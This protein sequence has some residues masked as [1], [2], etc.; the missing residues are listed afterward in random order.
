M[1]VEAGSIGERSRLAAKYVS[2]SLRPCRLTVS[3]DIVNDSAAI[4]G[5]ATDS[6]VLRRREGDSELNETLSAPVGFGSS[7]SA[8][9]SALMGTVFCPRFLP[10]SSKMPPR[11]F[12]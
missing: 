6:E 8:P 7:P 10:N 12:K 3:V 11:G 1:E 2:L 5:C 9:I 4:V